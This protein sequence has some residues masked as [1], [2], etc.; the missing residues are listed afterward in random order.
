[1]LS[2]CIHVFF[3]KI[4]SSIRYFLFILVWNGSIGLHRWSSS[5]DLDSREEHLTIRLGFLLQHYV[6][7]T[8]RTTTFSQSFS[9]CLLCWKRRWWGANGIQRRDEPRHQFEF[10]CWILYNEIIMRK[11]SKSSFNSDLSLMLGCYLSSIYILLLVLLAY[12]QH[13][14]FIWRKLH[15]VLCSYLFDGSLSA[16]CSIRFVYGGWCSA[17]TIYCALFIENHG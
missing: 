8:Y 12:L 16:L 4:F 13:Y 9:L 10:Q 7:N 1:M 2:Q 17:C 6:K 15:L 5:I 11:S 3:L 14:I